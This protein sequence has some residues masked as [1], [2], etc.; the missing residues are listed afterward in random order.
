MVGWFL[1]RVDLFHAYA[2]YE[3]EFFFAT[4]YIVGSMWIG[5]VWDCGFG[6]SF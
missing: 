2:G 1:G 6:T 3:W 4:L 5:L